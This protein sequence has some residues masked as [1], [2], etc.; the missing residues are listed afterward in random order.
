MSRRGP[1]A[2]IL[3]TGLALTGGAILWHGSA[4]ARGQSLFTCTFAMP[5][6]PDV[7]TLMSIPSHAKFQVGG[8]TYGPYNPRPKAANVL[9]AIPGAGVAQWVD[10]IASPRTAHCLGT[11]TFFDGIATL[12]TT[13]CVG[14]DG[15][16]GVQVD[17]MVNERGALFHL[18][19]VGTPATVTMSGH[20]QA[21]PPFV[22]L[23]GGVDTMVA[24]PYTWFGQGFS[25]DD[26]L[27]E[28]LVPS[29]G[30]T[31]TRVLP[32][33]PPTVDFWNGNSGTNFLIECDDA[34]VVRALADAKYWWP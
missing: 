25:A 20:S 29:V 17:F 4:Q 27:S 30:G 7:L 3:L 32:T 6:A 33:S 24:G 12:P 8:S 18:S 2:A 26:L 31:V 28:L 16:P 14:V 9:A 19:A 22:N 5:A 1:V 21:S 13:V 23:V 34:Y 11:G 10:T 15:T